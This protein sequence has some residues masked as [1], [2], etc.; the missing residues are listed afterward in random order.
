LF[1]DSNRIRRQ[2]FM[3]VQK[4]LHTIDGISTWVGKAAA[5]LIVVL[6]TVVCVEVFKRYIMNMPTAWIFDLDNILYGSLFMLCGAYTLAQNAHVRGDFLYSSMRPRTQAALD[7]VLYV[8]FFIPGIAALIYAGYHFAADSWRIAEHSNVTADGPPVYHFKS[9]IPIAGA[10]VMLQG[11]AEIMRA[12]VCLKTGEWPSRL[13]DVAETDVIEE[14]L[15]HSEY[16]DE[17]ARKIAIERAQRIDETAR[18]RGMGGD[19]NT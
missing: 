6:M 3:N 8:V 17:D 14:Q 5:W 15:A 2:P 1:P 11:I 9:V 19:L 13:H 18:Q 12:V 4:L 16:V 7:L 10:L